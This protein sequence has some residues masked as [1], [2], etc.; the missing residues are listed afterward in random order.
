[1]WEWLWFITRTFAVIY[2]MLLVVTAVFALGRW[3]KEKW[4]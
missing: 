2:L 3:V 4:L 1:M